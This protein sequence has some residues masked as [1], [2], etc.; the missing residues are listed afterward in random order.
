[1]MGLFSTVL[2]LGFV[3]YVLVRISGLRAENR[4]LALRLSRLESTINTGGRP[5]VKPT[6]PAVVQASVSDGGDFA[7]ETTGKSGPTGP[8]P[9]QPGEVNQ[10]AVKTAPVVSRPAVTAP[11]VR[12]AKVAA[13]PGFWQK[14]ERQ[15]MENW[16]GILGAVIMVMGVGF[17]GGYAFFRMTPFFRF[18][19]LLAFS[20]LLMGLFAFL[21]KKPDWLKL[22]LWLRGS[23]AA[24]LLFACLGAGG[25]PALQWLTNP[26]HALVLLCFGI[27]VN[28]YLGFI[29]GR[30]TIASIHVLLSL[31]ALSAA[32]QSHLIL[33]IGTVVALCGI[34]LT[35][36]EKW[37]YHLLLTISSFFFFHLFWFVRTLDDYAAGRNLIGLAVVIAVGLSAALVHY[38]QVYKNPRFEALPFVVHLL[39][40]LYF[41]IGLLCHAT[42]TPWKTVFLAG[43]AVAAFGLARHARRL[44]VRWLYLTDTLVAKLL[45]VIAIVSLRQWQVGYVAICSMTLLAGL[46]FAVVAAREEEDLLFRVGNWLALGAGLLLLL[47]AAV[48]WQDADWPQRYANAM[49]LA[50]CALAATVLHLSF[51]RGKGRDRGCLPGMQLL[52]GLMAV[53]IY[54]YLHALPWVEYGLLLAVPLLYLRQRNQDESFGRALVLFVLGVHGVFWVYFLPL[55]DL[56]WGMKAAHALPLL[57]LAVVAA[58]WSW[59]RVRQKHVAWIGIYLTAGNLFLL[60]YD[61]GRAYSPLIPGIVWLLL[62][63]PALEL[64]GILRRRQWAGADRHLMYVGHAF[65]LAFLCRYFLIH[66]QS[67]AYLGV[68]P[69]RLLVELLAI[70]VLLYWALQKPPAEEGSDLNWSCL[71]PLYV[72]ATLLLTVFVLVLEVGEFWYPLCWTAMAY[73][74]L[75][76]GRMLGERFSRLRGYSLLF[77]WAAAFH[78]AFLT[79]SYATPFDSWYRQ[80]W[81]IAAVTILLQVPYGYLICSRKA[82]D[83]LRWPKPLLFLA[84]PADFIRLHANAWICYPFFGAIAAFLYWNFDHAILTLLWVAEAF[85]IFA[86]SIMLRA[87]HFRYTALT[88][89]GLS[90]L[91]LVFYDL[92]HAG[93]ITRAVVFLGVGIIMLLIHVLFNQF[94]G[95]MADG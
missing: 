8:P 10:P 20:A 16:T 78:V 79:S 85:V 69:V 83:D 35:Y 52:A 80:A 40:W 25:F 44:P 56:A 32:P 46:M 11:P 62:S 4:T 21:R 49:W 5:V 65:L 13:A 71:V 30:Q 61:L 92:A 87:D 50:A 34:A 3:V 58:C 76:A 42:G 17:L 88:V 47:I 51:G 91:R 28:L 1:M 31:A 95:R 53:S 36:R 9:R 60:S 68:L 93:T 74:C 54:W 55:R 26:F 72:E 64:S 81:F 6:T 66:V 22:A 24:I 73:F 37:D 67:E 77:G 2:V 86:F 43:G 14:A 12:P 7:F 59:H 38:R 33:V 90:L 84:R 27:A 82:L 39:N 70:T 57:T 89:I 23:A 15:F 19:L 63:L 48:G 45:L 41:G 29:G 18:L 75:A 94:K